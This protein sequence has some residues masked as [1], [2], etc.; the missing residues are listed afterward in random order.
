MTLSVLGP[1]A[2]EFLF[3]DV[4]VFRIT[5]TGDSLANDCRP[6]NGRWVDSLQILDPNK[7]FVPIGNPFCPPSLKERGGHAM[8]DV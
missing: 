1:E 4:G 7:L 3:D 6:P 8:I 5:E 2:I